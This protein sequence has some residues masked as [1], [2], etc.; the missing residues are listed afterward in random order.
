MW[1]VVA[2]QIPSVVPSQIN[3]VIKTRLAESWGYLVEMRVVA[4]ATFAASDGLSFSPI[5]SEEP[6]ICYS[7]ERVSQRLQLSSSFGGAGTLMTKQDD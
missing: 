3:Y 2:G 4:E 5:I 1:I 6:A 7:T